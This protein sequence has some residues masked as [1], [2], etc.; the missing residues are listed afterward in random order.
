MPIYRSL[1]IPAVAVVL[2]VIITLALSMSSFLGRT[3]TTSHA[4]GAN[5]SVTTFHNDNLRTGQNT[6]ETLLNTSNVNANTFGK[7]V[8]Y[9]V[10]G[11]IY[12]QPLVVPNVTV[13][14]ATHNVV[15][16]ATE[17]DS[18]YAF[19]SD[20]SSAIAPLWKTSFINPP[21][22]TTVPAQDVYKKFPNKDITPQVGITGTPVIDSSTGTL[23]VV[24]MTKENGQYVQRLHALDITTGN[25]KPGSPQ[26]IQATVSG[27]GYDSV[28]GKISFNARTQNQRPA[29][30][31]SN[32]IVYISWGAF[33]DTDKYHGW[34]IGYRYNGSSLQQTSIYNDTPDG[35]EAGIWMSASGPATDSAGNIYLST[36]NGDFN[37]NT[38]GRNGGDSF[39]KISPQN[40]LN[41][42]DYFSPFNQEC[43]DGRDADISSG[44]PLLLPDQSGTN[45]SHLLLSTGKEGRTYLLDRDNM[46][47]FQSDPNLQCGSAEESR[48]DIDHVVQELPAGTTGSLFGVPGYWA[49]TANSGQSLYIG[50]YNDQLRAFKVNNGLL[51]TQATSK[52]PETF[53]FSG[54]T[55]SISSNGN[56]SGTGIVWINSPSSCTGPGCTPKGPGALRAYDA[57]NL[58]KELYNSEQNATRDRVDSYVK[59]SLPTVANGRAFVGTQTSLIVYGLLNNQ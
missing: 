38:D 49:G 13:N 58:S 7:R 30:L 44:G 27:T 6:S 28:N 45:H 19:D 48:T 2:V 9:P 17:N 33:G 55:P 3:F 15:F 5:T 47:Q 22:V 36:G 37:L 39:V 24:A 43:L 26:Q 23:Y 40:G 34:M 11:Q 4:A 8:A 21:A 53:A 10:D 35:Q 46:G 14:G 41:V 50:A 16:V 52:T 32:G 12:A 29:L 25:E 1:R 31:L 18:V 57:T 51:S 20:A 59:F 42:T 54:A 56:A